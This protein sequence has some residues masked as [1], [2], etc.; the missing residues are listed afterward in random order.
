MLEKQTEKCVMRVNWNCS[1]NHF[2]NVCL[3][4]F[5]STEVEPNQFII[6]T[7]W[8]IIQK[9]WT[10]K[11]ANKLTSL[12]I[13]QDAPVKQSLHDVI[14]IL[15]PWFFFFLNKRNWKLS[16]FFNL[17]W[18]Q[19]TLN[20]WDVSKILILFQIYHKFV[21]LRALVNAWL[22]NFKWHLRNPW[23][24]CSVSV[25]EKISLCHLKVV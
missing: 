6:S 4:F 5:L 10:V 16:H 13:N 1:V 15:S 14:V 25:E 8:L 3:W 12:H 23:I 22:W 20:I 17:E 24:T 7:I 9:A 11:N 21:A 18:K 2:S 19:K